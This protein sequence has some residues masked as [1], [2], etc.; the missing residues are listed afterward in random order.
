MKA[1]LQPAEGETVG[2]R[3]W[4]R[5]SS[6]L[7]HVALND[8]WPDLPERDR[9]AYA[10]VYIYAPQDRS[11][12]LDA[13]DMIALRCGADGGT[14]PFLNGK[15]VGRFDFVRELVLDSDRVDGLP[16]RKGWNQLV[17]KLH[18]P[19]GPWRFAARLVTASGEP[20]RDLTVALAPT[21]D[22]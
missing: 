20:A 21:D 3:C 14:K 15:C 9:I 22:V 18:N 19:S 12:L 8:I 4:Q 13:P 2:G 6:A 17:I 5:V 7:P 1:S 16:L 11:V 10:A